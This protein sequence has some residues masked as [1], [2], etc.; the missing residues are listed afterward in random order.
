MNPGLN[1]SGPSRPVLNSPP[2]V[3]R[4]LSKGSYAEAERGAGRG[5]FPGLQSG[6]RPLAQNSVFGGF[7][8]RDRPETENFEAWTPVQPLAQMERRAI[9]TRSSRERVAIGANLIRLRRSLRFGSGCQRHRHFTAGGGRKKPGVL[10]AGGLSRGTSL[11]QISVTIS[12]NLSGYFQWVISAGRFLLRWGEPF[13]C[14][15][16]AMFR[17]D[18][19]S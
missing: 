17:Y 9:S 3:R 4:S 5:I 14:S 18:P 7:F 13:N 12:R 8:E 19:R 6:R 10:P 2:D 1:R 15:A 16:R 11:W